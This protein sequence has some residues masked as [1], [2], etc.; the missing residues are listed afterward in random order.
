MSLHTI[1]TDVLNPVVPAAPVSAHYQYICVWPDG[2]Y[3]DPDELAEMSHRGDDYANVAV[4][5]DQEDWEAAQAYFDHI[6]SKIA[7]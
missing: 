1:I 7:A 3:C 4:G 6:N 5:P 2:M